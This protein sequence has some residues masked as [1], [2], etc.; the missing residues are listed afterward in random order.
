MKL[1]TFLLFL[2]LG[3]LTIIFALSSGVIKVNPLITL[4]ILIN[5]ITTHNFFDV[6]WNQ[7]LETILLKL[8]LPRIFLAFLVGGG[9]SLVG[10]L[11]QALTKNSLADPYILGVSSGAS[12]G[13]VLSLIIGINI[14]GLGTPFMA[15]LGAVTAAVLVFRIANIGGNYS[16]TK[17]VLTGIA[18]SSMFSSITTFITF[19]AQNGDLYTALF[20]IVGSLSG[21]KWSSIYI[22][23]VLLLIVFGITMFF[24]R[25]LDIL[26]L[27]EESSKILG[28]NTNKIRIIIILTSTLLTGILVSIS[29]VIGFI[30]LIIPHI[31]RKLTSSKHRVLIP[32]SIFLGGFF[33]TLADTFSRVVMSPN[34]LPVGIV[35]SFLG[36]PFFLWIMK[37]SIYNFNK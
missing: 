13:A 36:A 24:N 25:E 27:G 19:S 15:F 33:L 30:G 26:L 20:W 29:G 9:L 22:L 3:I 17:L 31:S 21:A 11:M 12:T 1:K 32:V 23:T 4:K 35:T 37:K 28:V 5:S 16:S 7:N 8:R 10:V 6:T 34:E 2:L 18:I 14:G